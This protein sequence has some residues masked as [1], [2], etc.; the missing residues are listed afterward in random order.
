MAIGWHRGDS[1]GLPT[2]PW[3]GGIGDVPPCWGVR[4]E[5]E[6]VLWFSR[7]QRLSGFSFPPVWISVV[8]HSQFPLNSGTAVVHP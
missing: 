8:A 7:T 2:E 4:E 5:L 6:G 1:P 3:D